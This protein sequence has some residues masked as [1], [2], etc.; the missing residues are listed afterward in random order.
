M[1]EWGQETV[2]QIYCNTKDNIGNCAKTLKDQ[3]TANFH[4]SRDPSVAIRSCKY[5]I[6]IVSSG[7]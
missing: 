4:I 7:D 2:A 1:P 3:S 6:K 5:V